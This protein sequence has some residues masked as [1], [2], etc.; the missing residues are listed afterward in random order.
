MTDIECPYCEVEQEI[1]H[2]DGYGLA[3]DEVYE[4]ECGICE[5]VF[6]Y[7]TTIHLHHEARRAPCLNGAPHRYRPTTTVPREFTKMECEDCGHRRPC[8]DEELATVMGTNP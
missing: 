5:Q 1:C 4:Q 6:A 3:E 2:D 8:T 7:T